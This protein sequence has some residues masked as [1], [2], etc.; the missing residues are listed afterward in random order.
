MI[1]IKPISTNIRQLIKTDNKF[2]ILEDYYKFEK[3]SNMYCLQD[4]KIIWFAELPSPEDFYSNEILFLGNN[5]IK[6]G[7]WSGFSVE[8]DVDTGKILNK[9]FTK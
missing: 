4:N 2:I 3:E 6:S 9:S 8:I 1:N 5:V 7:T